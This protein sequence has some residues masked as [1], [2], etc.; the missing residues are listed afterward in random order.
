MNADFSFVFGGSE[1]SSRNAD[2]HPCA[3]GRYCEPGS[4]V[5][6]TQRVTEY[7]AFDALWWTL[8]FENTGNQ[9]SPVISD[10]N[11]SD[12]VVQL[13]PDPPLKPGFLPDPQMTR[14]VSFGGMAEGR[15]YSENDEKSAEEFAPLVEYLNRKRHYENAGGRSS[16]TL[17][18][19]FALES[20]GE[21]VFVAVG[22]T[23]SWRADFE[24]TDGGVRIRTGLKR[25]GFYL[26]PGEKLRT[27]SVLIM[28]SAAGED[29]FNKFRRLL[30]EH[31]SPD[32]C[33]GSK[34]GSLLAFELWG[35]LPS[36]EMKRRIAALKRAGVAFEQI[37]LDAG[38][39][40]NCTDCREP[41]SGD[42]SRFTGD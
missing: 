42:W 34:T 18:P 29:G 21:K 7:E 9:N 40:G 19:F 31:F 20:H 30:R 32:V 35:G 3:G 8:D 10:I 14:V 26:L 13:P 17:L 22:W 24:K 27:S 41:F 1:F 28:R 16:D 39:Y 6:V 4:G 11:D 37:W 5:K 2:F 36:E 25:T 15:F 12:L 23:G 33:S 38:W